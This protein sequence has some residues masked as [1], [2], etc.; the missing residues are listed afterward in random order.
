M[1]GSSFWKDSNF[2][3]T[4]PRLAWGSPGSCRPEAG[5]WVACAWPGTCVCMQ[6]WAYGQQLLLL[7]L[8]L[9]SR[10]LGP[11]WEVQRAEQE[12][13]WDSEQAAGVEKYWAVLAVCW[14]PL[15]TQVPLKWVFPLPRWGWGISP[16]SCDSDR[17]CAL[18]RGS[19]LLIQVL[20]PATCSGG[21]S[22]ALRYWHCLFPDPQ[23]CTKPEPGP[24]A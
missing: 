2:G 3:A 5:V 17:S 20:K 18:D 19:W 14:V 21:Q 23:T 16:P 24:R 7:A 13:G 15:A 6:A 4:P 12:R 1:G 22:G 8:A 9:L 11:G 10:P